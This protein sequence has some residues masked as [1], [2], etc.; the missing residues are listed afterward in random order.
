MPVNTNYRYTD[1]E[2]VYLW[3]NADAVAVVFHGTFADRCERV[4][5]RLPAIRSWLWVDDGSGPCPPWAVPYEDARR[6]R[7][8]GQ[9]R[10]RR[11][12]GPATTSS[13]ST[14]AAPPACRR[15]SCG[16]R[17]TSSARSMRS[18]KRRLP[19]APDLTVITRALGEART[20]Q[21]A[22]GAA[23]ARHR[24]VQRDEQPD[25]QRLGRHDGRAPVR[26]GRT[27]RHDRAAPRQLDVDRRRRLRQADRAG[28][29]RRAAA[30]GHLDAAGDRVERCHVEPGDEG[31]PAAPQRA[32]DHG[33]LARFLRGGRDGEQHDDGRRQP[34]GRPARRAS[35]SD[36]TPRC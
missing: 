13:C 8:A 35:C 4:R 19:T 30:M 20:A 3:D 14:R 33:R 15:A 16:A 31:R 7:D 36:P 2:L 1:D 12:A 27:A 17:T 9:V 25:G 21:P 34:R 5:A 26:P 24:A 10:R 32:P 11:G 23:H 22:R 6:R 28:A 18:N 29:R